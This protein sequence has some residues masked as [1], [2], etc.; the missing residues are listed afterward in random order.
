MNREVSLADRAGRG[1]GRRGAWLLLLGIFLVGLA[2]RLVAW[3]HSMVGDELSTLWIVR[4]FDLAGTVGEVSSDAEISP[5]LYFVLAWLASKLGSAP[6]LVRLP[7]LIAG[8]AAIPLSYLLANR[9]SGRVAGLIAAAAMALSPF[10]VAFSA[11]GRAYTLMVALLIGSTL[12]MLAARPGGKTAWWVVFG[13]LTCAAMYSHYTAVYFLAAQLVWLL[14][15]SPPSRVPA[16]A[17][18]AGAGV[19]YLPWLPSTLDDLDSPTLPILEA[20]QGSGLADK[21]LGVKQLL[22]GQPLVDPTLLPLLLLAGGALLLAAGLHLWWH[23][24]PAGGRASGEGLVLLLVLTLATAVFEA[25]LALAG[26][27]TF[28]AR[29]LAATWAALPA[30]IGVAAAL[31]SPVIGLTA[32]A[33]LLAG[34]GSG[35]VRAADPGTATLDFEGAAAWIDEQA[36][37]DDVVYDATFVSPVP[38]TSLDVYLPQGRPEFRPRIPADEPP[39]LLAAGPVGND[40][41]VLDEALAATGG[42][43]LFVLASRDPVPPGRET[44]LFAP[45]E[46][47]ELPRGWRIVR[48][49]TFP[50]RLPLTVTE[51]ERVGRAGS[52][53]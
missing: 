15:V 39:F 21:W 49:A 9:L 10:M 8:L 13:L 40:Q 45:E 48:T 27:D 52:G 38:L 46:G 14:V 47:A 43:R 30:L 53:G 36:G 44:D 37:P 41:P 28:G 24:P 35:A 32:A 25:M 29:N 50:G 33:L 20:I 23:R 31:C 51:V 11:T 18:S 4:E 34:F 26:T 7:A 1:I 42:N 17:A 3:G 12:A 16:L 22:A 2:F 5:P 6:E 19:L